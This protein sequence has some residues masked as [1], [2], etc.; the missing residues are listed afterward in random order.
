[1]ED[2]VL[3][4]DGFT[5]YRDRVD[6][7][8]NTT[9]TITWLGTSNVDAL[10]GSNHIEDSSEQLSRQE[11]PREGN[12]GG[13]NHSNENLILGAT[14]RSISNSESQ[15]SLHQESEGQQ[16]SDE[17]ISESQMQNETSRGSSLCSITD[18][19]LDVS[20]ISLNILETSTKFQRARRKQRLREMRPRRKTLDVFYFGG[21]PSDKI[22]W[23]H[24]KSL[25]PSPTNPELDHVDLRLKRSTL[26]SSGRRHTMGGSVDGSDVV[27][28]PEDEVLGF[29]AS[30]RNGPW[31]AV[32]SSSDDLV[33]GVSRVAQNGKAVSVDGARRALGFRRG[34]LYATAIC[35][36]EMKKCQVIADLDLL[37]EDTEF[38][39]TQHWL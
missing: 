30:F 37:E 34:S 12:S 33:S 15:C 39:V 4:M 14:T 26:G 3:K 1:M 29:P 31:P 5:T 17:K 24:S 13:I 18:D 7:A 8:V 19:V 21:E 32:Y 38:E 9:E 20:A 11:S 36:S 22:S 2:N 23:S 27:A 10:G 16:S 25:T 6:S 35:V 28:N